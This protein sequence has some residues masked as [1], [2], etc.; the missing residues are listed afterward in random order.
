MKRI[1]LLSTALLAACA[2]P[3]PGTGAASPAAAPGP[4]KL[5]KVVMLMRHGIR[6]PTKAAVVPPGYSDERWPDWPVDYGLLT[7]R[8]GAGVRLLGESDRLWFGD[9]GLFPGGCP[10]AGTIVLK[11]SYK[12]RTI[13][14]A[15]NW[16]AGFMP[17]CAADV[18]HPADADDDAIFHG[19]D[20]APPSFD[21]KRAYDASL[22]EAPEGGL[23]ADTERHRGELTLLAKVLNCAVPACPL[24]AEPSRLIAQPH[25]RPDLEGPLDVGS[26]A[27]QTLLL[28]YLEGMPMEQVGW[29]RVSRAEIEQLLRFH[30]LKFRYA[31]RP[32]YIAAAAAAP[33][34]GEIVAALGDASPARL[35]LLAGHDTNVADLGG[36][37][38]LHWQVPSYPADE[39]PPGSALGFELVSDAK[40]E[41]YVRAFYRGQTMDQLRNLEPLG[42]GDALFRRYLP[43]PGCGNSAEATACTWTAFTRL[44]A[45][46]G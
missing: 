41:R 21:G 15:R 33:I 3:A 13:D 34:V 12:Q 1:F 45:P 16:A 35:T 37:F 8:G 22:A 28:E 10:A 25:D 31:N 7:P 18:A 24:V 36:F 38:D 6:P 39:V 26:T 14:T 43:I 42:R 4:L 44:G 17:G 30:P 40:G 2:A 27:S 46:R 32:G 20:G 9:R 11:A 29:G 19:L 23:A 5:E